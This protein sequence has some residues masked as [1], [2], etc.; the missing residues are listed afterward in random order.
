MSVYVLLL[1]QPILLFISIFIDIII[2]TWLLIM[3][4]DDISGCPHGW[5]TYSDHCYQVNTDAKYQ[6]AASADCQS[7]GAELAS[8][9]DVFE[10]DFINSL[11]YVLPLFR[12]V[13]GQ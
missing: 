6:S 2:Y 9:T 7:Q 3:R 4:V 12:P 13:I 8:I 5:E 11:L 10:S 1:Q